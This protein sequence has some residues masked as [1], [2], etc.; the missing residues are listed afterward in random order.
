M[1]MPDVLTRAAA[2]ILPPPG[3]ARA[4]AAQSI[5]YAAGTGFYFSGSAIFFTQVIGLRADQ[6]GLGFSIAGLPSFLAI[7]TAVA[8]AEAAGNAGMAVYTLEVVPIEQR[9]RVKAYQRS[10]LNIGFAL[11]TLGT[12]VALAI[13]TRPAYLAIVL[14]NA[15]LQ[16]INAVFIARMPAVDRTAALSRRRS[17]FVVIADRPFLAVA[18]LTGLLGLY[19]ALTEVVLP[20][21]ALDRTDAPHALIPAMFLLNCLL[22]IVLQVPASR[23]SD[24]LPGAVRALRR[25][26]WIIALSCAAI[27]LAPTVHGWWA[28]I[29]LVTAATFLAWAEIV[30][31]AG[32]WG[33]TATLLPDGNRGAYLGVFQ[34]CSRSQRMLAPA[35]L[36]VLALHT[37]GWGWLALAVVAV[38]AGA[39]VSPAVAWA[40]RCSPITTTPLHATPLRV[41]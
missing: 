1:T 21:V 3:V 13:G 27:A 36:T 10:A 2:R 25:T 18:A 11:G 12:G 28:G 29:A 24:T 26:G 31:S 14:V 35:G 41:G 39:A 23:G 40:A 4:L 6:I 16:L 5:V 22:V 9:V 17:A 19:Q 15:A 38:A 37:G 30:H 7:M 32:L 8:L 34:L 33:L 20:L